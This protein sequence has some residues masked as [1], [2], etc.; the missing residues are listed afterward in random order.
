MV[1]ALLRGISVGIVR[2]Y[3]PNEARRRYELQ[4]PAV[5]TDRASQVVWRQV[6]SLTAYDYLAASSG[7]KG[8]ALSQAKLQAQARIFGGSAP[9]WVRGL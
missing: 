4:Y 8:L 7:L 2:T 5:M 3:W 6:D 1:Q 9:V